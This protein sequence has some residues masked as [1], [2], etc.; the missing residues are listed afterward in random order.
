MGP[1]PSLLVEEVLVRVAAVVLER[2]A[3]PGVAPS[4]TRLVVRVVAVVES[5]LQLC[6]TE[7]IQN[8]RQSVR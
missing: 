4:A 3:V 5:L 7:D 6:S 2:R 8:G 1:S